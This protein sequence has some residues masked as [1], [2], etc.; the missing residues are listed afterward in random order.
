MARAFIQSLRVQNYGCIKDAA[1]NLTPL[2]A[3]IG[4]NDT[5]KSTV[6]RALKVVASLGARGLGRGDSITHEADWQHAGADVRLLCTLHP[7]GLEFC[8]TRDAATGGAY[9]RLQQ[10]ERVH[11]EVKPLPSGVFSVHREG[12]DEQAV[13]AIGE[14][15]AALGGGVRLLRLDPDALRAPS[16]LIPEQEGR[17]WYEERGKGLPGVYDAILNRGDDAFHRIVEQIRPLFPTVRQLRLRVVDASTKAL[18]CELASGERVD[19]AAMSDGLLYFL[20]FAA[21]RCLEP[22]SLLLVEEPENGLH[23]ARTRE[24]M[25]VLREISKTTQVVLATHSPLVVNE[26]DGKEVTVLTRTAEHG[27][28]AAL[29]AD[30]P[31]YAQRSEVYK[32][33]ELWVSYCDGGQEEPL[34][35]AAEPPEDPGDDGEPAG[36]DDPKGA[37]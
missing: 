7:S 24:V 10:G 3:L 27:T 20:A 33:G 1:W 25:A 18:Q 37:S 12:A 21:I 17:R 35:R 19:A 6:L 5:G 13:A 36:G 32:N 14:A 9:Q 26:L 16:S 15:R 8:V 30:T 22:V 11:R 34:F 28:R 29:L 31:N 4:P 2:H 23:P